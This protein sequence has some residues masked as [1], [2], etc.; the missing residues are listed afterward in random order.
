MVGR[1]SSG[2]FARERHAPILCGCACL[3]VGVKKSDNF[4]QLPNVIRDAGRH[5]WRAANRLVNAAKVVMH[6]EQRERVLMVFN[7]LGKC[8][9]QPREP[10][11]AHANRKIRPFNE[12]R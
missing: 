9:C 1:H 10:A 6:E 3:F 11:I 7:L 2:M 12:A 5:C 4:A 8:V